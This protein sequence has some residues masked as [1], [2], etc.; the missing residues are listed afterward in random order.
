MLETVGWTLVII[1]LLPRALRTLDA[2]LFALSDRALDRKQ[3]ITVKPLPEPR[4]PK[5]KR[6]S[7]YFALGIAAFFVTVMLTAA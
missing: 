7:W 4:T 6:A 5:E 3:V 1:A 2:W